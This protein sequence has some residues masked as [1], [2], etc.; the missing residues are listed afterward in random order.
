MAPRKTIAATADLIAINDV[1]PSSDA[2]IK[3][4]SEFPEYHFMYRKHDDDGKPAF[5][6]DQDGNNKLPTFETISFVKVYG[7]R[8][9][10]TG[11]VDPESARSFYIADPAVLG[12][13]FDR[14]LAKLQAFCKDGKY[15]MYTEDD[16]FKKRNPEAFR[17]A[18]EKVE[19]TSTIDQLRARNEE[20]EK[21]L[22]FVKKN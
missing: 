6:T 12:A 7:T 22:G 16:H 15:R 18:K 14:V 8:D 5:H 13:D 3:F 17:I 20:L 10:K 1:R 9:P 2:A 11:K 21:R 4:I 19:L